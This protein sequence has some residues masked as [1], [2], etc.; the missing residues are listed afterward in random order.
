MRRVVLFMS[1]LLLGVCSQQTC[2]YLTNYSTPQSL[3]DPHSKA[4][5]D[6]IVLLLPEFYQVLDGFVCSRPCVTMDKLAIIS[7]LSRIDDHILDKGAAD[8]IIF[9]EGYPATA[10]VRDIRSS[11]SRHVDFVNVDAV[12]LRPPQGVDPFLDQP[13]YSKRG[14]WRYQQMQRFMITDLFRFPVMDNVRFIL[15]I[16]FDATFSLPIKA[17]FDVMLRNPPRMNYFLYICRF[18]AF[19]HYFIPSL[20]VVYVSNLSPV[21]PSNTLARR[22]LEEFM[23]SAGIESPVDEG[24]W[25]ELMPAA[26]DDVALSSPPGALSNNQAEIMSVDFFRRPRVQALMDF[27]INHEASPVFRAGWTD[28]TARALTL[29]LLA[30][31]SEVRTSLPSKYSYVHPDPLPGG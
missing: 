12:F 7:I 2:H 10:A 4:S 30:S 9:H 3:V 27:I 8:V 21:A 31:K 25:V 20:S 5:R 24:L 11:T 29:A 18:Y 15:K 16:D 22:I 14:K 28:A 6:A 17:P 1:W 19:I 26:E 23:I 13:H